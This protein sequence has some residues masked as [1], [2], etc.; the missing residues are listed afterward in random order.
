MYV[1]N[2]ID[3]EAR[4]S[5]LH[6]RCAGPAGS[7]TLCGDSGCCAGTCFTDSMENSHCCPSGTSYCSG[8][9]CGPDS[10]SVCVQDLEEGQDVCCARHRPAHF[11]PASV[12]LVLIHSFVH[13]FT[14]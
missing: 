1:T 11:A 4:A 10:Q 9:C 5:S 8:E 3:A 13:Q 12:F 6:R 2:H 14:T 7:I